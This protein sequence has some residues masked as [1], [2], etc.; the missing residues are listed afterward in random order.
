MAMQNRENW[1]RLLGYSKKRA[2]S[3]LKR[4]LGYLKAGESRRP[5]EEDRHNA[6]EMIWRNKSKHIG[7]NWK[8]PRKEKGKGISLRAEG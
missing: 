7:E 4:Q 8:K 3:V 2:S 5:K 6:L 1:C